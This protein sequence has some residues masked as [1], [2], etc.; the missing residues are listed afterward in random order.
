MLALLPNNLRAN[1]TNNFRLGALGG[2]ISASDA[3]FHPSLGAEIFLWDK[4]SAKH[5]A[6]GYKKAD[7]TMTGT[8]TSIGYSVQPTSS[9]FFLFRVGAA[10]GRY[11]TKYTG[12]D[13]S[14]TLDSKRGNVS[15]TTGL[16]YRL[17]W[18]SVYMSAQME[19][20]FTPAYGA[21]L[22]AFGHQFFCGLGIGVDL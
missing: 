5:L 4:W 11:L 2:G 1:E 18:K 20:F 19:S 21:Y 14:E 16:D 15:F 7:Y 13:S 3:N 8:L 10:Y 12:S 17:A 22:Q 9:K 6:W